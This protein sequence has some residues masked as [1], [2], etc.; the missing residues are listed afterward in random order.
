MGKKRRN[1]LARV[2]VIDD[3]DNVRTPLRTILEMSGHE[4]DEAGNGLDGLE[5]F[6]ACPADLVIT[7]LNMPRLNGEAFI[8]RLRTDFPGVKIIVMTAD[9]EAISQTLG[10]D[11]AVEKPFRLNEVLETVNRLLAL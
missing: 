2:L 9:R 4:V 6:S 3:E 1:K 11:A 7:D 5:K 8:L 10:A